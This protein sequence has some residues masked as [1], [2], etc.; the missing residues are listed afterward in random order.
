MKPAFKQNKTLETLERICTMIRTIP[1]SSTSGGKRKG[2]RQPWR[3]S[4]QREVSHVNRR[5][6]KPDSHSL[7]VAHLGG[8]GLNRY[9]A[10]NERKRSAKRV[11]PGEKESE[12]LNYNGYTRV[13]GPSKLGKLQGKGIS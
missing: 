9:R 4:Y 13:E 12:G 6:K 8:G 3:G 10:H 11:E 5:G 1:R 2:V 7:G